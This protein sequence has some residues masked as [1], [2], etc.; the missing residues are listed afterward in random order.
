MNPAQKELA[1]LAELTLN[2][3]VF[4]PIPRGSKACLVRIGSG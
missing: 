1:H 2:N 3:G 4:L